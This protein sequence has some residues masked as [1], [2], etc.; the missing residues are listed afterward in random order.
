MLLLT[1]SEISSLLT[2]PEYIPIIE[3][4]FRLHANG[5]ALDPALAHVDA[6][7]GEFHIKAG[8]L[9]GDPPYFALKVNGGFFH[10]R[11]RFGLPNIQGL[12]VLSR[13]DNGVPL[14]A[15]DSI[16]IT[17]QRTGAATA[18]AAKYL[19]RP[20]STI[21]TIC[22]CGNQ[23]RVQLRALH[24]VLPLERV[25]A[26]SRT[27]GRAEQFAAEMTTQLGI[28]VAA[29]TDLRRALNE[30]DVCVTCTPSKAPLIN[31]DHVPAGM[32]IAAV[33]ADSPD[34][35]ELDAELISAATVVAD[36][37]CQVVAVGETRHAIA[38]GL[39]RPEQIYAE[40]G[41]IIT[42]AV[43]APTS[44]GRVI[45][46]DSTGTALQDVAAAAAVYERA[47]KQGIG[48]KWDPA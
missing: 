46:F 6:N 14:A 11:A 17:I 12:I 43:P 29:V 7:D 26:W 32:F 47:C 13:A 4:A 20:D 37:R 36:L 48:L 42:G 27:Y 31:R 5:A 41:E 30:S 9:R 22:G 2:F 23:G 16:E 39:M 25:F 3:N 28:S 19:A 24:A 44:S 15:M 40:L 10:N 8:G 1:R 35:Q 34:K 38:A 45:V 18:V 21:C 33:G